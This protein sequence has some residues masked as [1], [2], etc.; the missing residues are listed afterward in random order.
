MEF[1]REQPVTITTFI[2]EIL[3]GENDD[4]ESDDDSAPPP[5]PPPRSESLKMQ[6]LLQDTLA[7]AYALN[8]SHSN[9]ADAQVYAH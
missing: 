5:L 3:R 1:S 6:Q 4:S 2:S 7:A 9:G 8:G